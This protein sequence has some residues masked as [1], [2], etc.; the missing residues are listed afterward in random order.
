[1]IKI[2]GKKATGTLLPICYWVVNWMLSIT[3]GNNLFHEYLILNYSHII[4]PVSLNKKP[5][6]H[7]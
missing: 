3:F 5:P 4:L 6:L 1:M 7:A 2:P